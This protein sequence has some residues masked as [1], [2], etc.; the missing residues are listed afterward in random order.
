MRVCLAAV[1]AGGD[2]AC[3][4]QQQAGVQ[5]RL[6]RQAETLTRQQLWLVAAEI[7]GAS[8]RYTVV[9]L[10]TAGVNYLGGFGQ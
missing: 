1:A 2:Q 5:M 9:L 8:C 3:A 6:G 4:V 10:A 7:T